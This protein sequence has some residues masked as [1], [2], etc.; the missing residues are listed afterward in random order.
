MSIK[1]TETNTFIDNV[2]EE[3][4]EPTEE[5]LDTLKTMVNDWFKY[6]DQIRKLQIAI[7]ERKVYQKAL[8]TK[9]EHFMFNYKYKDLNTQHGKIKA[10]ERKVKVPVKMSEIKEKILK[11]NHLSGEELL[12]EIFNTDR[13]TVI[14]KNIKRVIP[15]VNLQI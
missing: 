3:H 9:I 10:N 11:L 15:T 6:D 7:K 5:E 1:S 12:N 4:L 2:L 14:K 8:N 13:P